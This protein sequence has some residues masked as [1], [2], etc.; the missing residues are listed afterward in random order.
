MAGDFGFAFDGVVEDGHTVGVTRRRT[1][2]TRRITSIEPCP[3]EAESSIHHPFCP[4][5]RII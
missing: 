2:D 4:P 5:K 3:S 1:R